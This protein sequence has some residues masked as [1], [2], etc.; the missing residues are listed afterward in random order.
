MGMRLVAYL[1]SFVPEK[2]RA[3]L[4]ASAGH[5]PATDQILVEGSDNEREDAFR[6]QRLWLALHPGALLLSQVQC[7]PR[8]KITHG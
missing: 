1:F 2:D 4:A 8:L 7:S 3:A 6:A 5:S